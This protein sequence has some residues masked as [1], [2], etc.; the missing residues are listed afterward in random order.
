MDPVLL[1]SVFQEAPSFAGVRDDMV[2]PEYF[3]PSHLSGLR[4]VVEVAVEGEIVEERDGEEE[5]EEVS[6][7]QEQPPEGG[8]LASSMA[9]LLKT[10]G[11]VTEEKE[12][13]ERP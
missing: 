4:P 9:P 11:H 10:N 12:T 2:A 13:G 8:Q 3:N 1:D 5:E 7:S 6:P